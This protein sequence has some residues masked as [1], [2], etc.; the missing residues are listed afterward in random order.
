[1]C[2][3]PSERHLMQDA[4]Y[5]HWT[6]TMMLAVSLTAILMVRLSLVNL[7]SAAVC[8]ACCERDMPMLQRMPS[9]KLACKHVKSGL[10]CC[11]PPLDRL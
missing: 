3:L 6:T 10:A 7:A 9:V 2:G 1:M 5:H 4:L 8:N 11:R